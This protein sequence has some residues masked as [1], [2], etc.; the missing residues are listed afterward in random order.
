[1]GD[2]RG[3][4]VQHLVPPTDGL[5]QRG[6]TC[7]LCL[8]SETGLDDCDQGGC[9]VVGKDEPYRGGG[10]L[11]LQ[12]PPE[13]EHRWW[14]QLVDP[15]RELAALVE[16]PAAGPGLPAIG[17]LRRVPPPGS[18]VLRSGQRR[19]DCAADR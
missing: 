5:L 2:E 17:E 14:L 13:G 15:H 19:P 8:A 18:Q 12:P 4:S 9:A 1:M 7:C 3:E 11:L 16:E 6:P 10:L